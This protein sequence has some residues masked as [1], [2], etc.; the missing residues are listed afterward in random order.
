MKF[1]K[2]LGR[3]QSVIIL[4]F[5]YFVGV[6]IIWLVSFIFRKDFLDKKLNDKIS[7]WQ[8]R[9]VDVPNLENSKRQF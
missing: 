8:A 2:V 3:I 5:I 4:F 7:F 6:G 1:A 9:H